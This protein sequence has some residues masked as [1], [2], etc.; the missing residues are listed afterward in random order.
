MARKAIATEQPKQAPA[1]EPEAPQHAAEADLIADVSEQRFQD[2]LKAA[3]R[4]R[5]N[6]GPDDVIVVGPCGYRIVRRSSGIA[7]GMRLVGD[8]LTLVIPPLP[9]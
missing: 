7:Y 4:A 1:A 8:G 2:A 6:V 9:R 5:P 3:H